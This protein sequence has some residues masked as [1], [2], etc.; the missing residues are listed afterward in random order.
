MGLRPENDEIFVRPAGRP[1]MRGPR[2]A[3]D[4]AADVVDDVVSHLVDALEASGARH[5]SLAAFG[6]AAIRAARRRP[7]AGFS[8]RVLW[9]DDQPETIEPMLAALRRLGVEVDV[10]MSTKEAIDAVFTGSYAGVVS[11]MRRE[12]GGVDHPFAGIELAR[13][14]EPSSPGRPMLVY[15]GPYG[16]QY[17]D[18]LR[19][20]GVVAV[21]SRATVL[22]DH[23]TAWA[24]V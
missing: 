8:G 15:T 3:R 24:R 12:E 20:A 19:D 11:D 7:R 2:R 4:A 5:E 6:H 10:V 18:E 1:R 9:V 16:I 21:T 13:A 17:E 23:V 22:L 14:L